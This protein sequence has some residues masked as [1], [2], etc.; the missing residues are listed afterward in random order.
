VR[1][2][3]GMLFILLGREADHREALARAWSIISSE[4]EHYGAVLNANRT[5]Y[6]TQ[7]Q[8]PFLTSMIRAVYENP[9]SFPP[10]PRGAPSKS[11][12]QRMHLQKDSPRG[13]GLNTQR[14]PPVCPL[15]RLAERSA[16]RDGR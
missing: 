2:M 12:V 6:L 8:P 13:R 14:V 5:Y 10:T 3:V 16:P 4:I 9:A 15:L 1:C 11:L 7:S